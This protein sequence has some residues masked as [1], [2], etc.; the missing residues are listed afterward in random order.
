MLDNPIL[1]L[2]FNNEVNF[3]PE[4]IF[5]VDGYLEPLLGSYDLPAFQVLLISAAVGLEHPLDGCGGYV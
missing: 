1:A 5:S 4:I 3:A 2:P